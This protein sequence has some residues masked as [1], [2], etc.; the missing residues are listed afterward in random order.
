MRISYFTIALFV[1]LGQISWA[2]EIL[3]IINYHVKFGE[4]HFESILKQKD[5]FVKKY[6]ADKIRYAEASTP[7]DLRQAL[8]NTLLPED[9]I[10][11]IYFSS[12]AVHAHFSSPDT[13]DSIAMILAPNGD[14]MG[15]QLTILATPNYSTPIDKSQ[16]NGETILKEF[17][18]LKGR[19]TP[20]PDLVLGACSLFVNHPETAR[21]QASRL[22]S[23]FGIPSEAKGFVYANHSD[24]YAFGIFATLLNPPRLLRNTKSLKQYLVLQ[25]ATIGLIGATTWAALTE[26]Y[27]ALT[28]AAI[29]AGAMIKFSYSANRGFIVDFANEA[30]RVTQARASKAVNLLKCK[31]ALLVHKTK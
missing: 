2:G 25:G 12:H 1:L 19:F 26:H 6:G 23:A 31:D 4:P 16:D 13:G 7:A 21:I 20:N 27:V 11:A 3:L 18:P 15:N 10:S 14:E 17:E 9:Q 22:R 24:A 5:D 29:L 8:D 28:P 30:P